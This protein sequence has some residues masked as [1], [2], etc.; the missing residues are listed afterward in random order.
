M[1]V[2]FAA[3]SYGVDNAVIASGIDPKDLKG[4]KV[5]APQAYIGQLLM[6]VW[7]DANVVNV[8]C[9]ERVNLNADEAVGPMVSGDLA[10]LERDITGMMRQQAR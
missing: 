5:V 8:N 10:A 1:Q 6:V 9:V 3:P 4:K 7:L 2:T